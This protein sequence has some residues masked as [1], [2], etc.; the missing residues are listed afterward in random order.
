MVPG[1]KGNAPARH[2]AGAGELVF[3]VF[4]P[5]LDRGAVTPRISYHRAGAGSVVGLQNRPWQGPGNEH[6]V[7]LRPSSPD[8]RE[9]CTAVGVFSRVL[10]GARIDDPAVRGGAEVLLDTLPQ[11]SGAPETG[12]GAPKDPCAWHGGTLALFP[13]GGS[14]WTHWFER[15]LPTLL[16]SR[17]PD[18][19]WAPQGLAGG[20][21][22]S[23][24][25]NVLTLQPPQ[26]LRP[27]LQVGHRVEEL[28]RLQR[29][30]M[31]S[32]CR[33]RASRKR[34]S[35][36]AASGAARL[37]W[38]GSKSRTVPEGSCASRSSTCSQVSR[39]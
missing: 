28:P 7:A 31:V 38:L 24:A 29:G 30:G 23:T 37:P 34:R 19:S 35:S 15:A 4:V 13:V 14:A 20:R 25:L 17:S 8:D 36:A 22:A 10:L 1:S 32:W 18:G 9:V 11:T 27:R 5:R 12:V 3:D 21:V 26:P 16:D 39:L 33:S 2:L 6:A